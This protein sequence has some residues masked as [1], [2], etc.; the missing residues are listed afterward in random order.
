MQGKA[1]RPVEYADCSFQNPFNRRIKGFT[2]LIGGDPPEA[3][4][5]MLWERSVLPLFIPQE[6][7]HP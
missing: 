3:L 7:I 4:P 1:K 2:L 6:E 5:L